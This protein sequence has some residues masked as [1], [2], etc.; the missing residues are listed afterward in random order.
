M[1][2]ADVDHIDLWQQSEGKGIVIDLDNT[3]LHG[4]FSLPKLEE[5]QNP[6]VEV[7]RVEYYW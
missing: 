7:F 1:S 4:T 6:L 5:M 2:Q 3:L